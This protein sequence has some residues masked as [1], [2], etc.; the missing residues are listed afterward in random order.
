MQIRYFSSTA[1]QSFL[2]KFHNQLVNST[3]KKHIVQELLKPVGLKQPPT[4]DTKYSAGNSLR[5]MFNDQKTIQRTK[6]LEAE[7][8][9]SGFYDVYTFR[10]TKGKLFL[11]PPSFWKSEKALYFPHLQGRTL[12]SSSLQNTEDVMRGKISI[13]RLFTSNV[14]DDL[15]KSYFTN[16]EVNLLKDESSLTC[17]EDSVPT[18]IVEINLTENFMKSLFVRLAMGKLRK[19]VPQERHSRFFV[20]DRNQMPFSVREELQI[21]NLYTGYVLVVDPNLKIRWMACG[22]ADKKDF[23]LLWKCVRGLKKEFN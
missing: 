13:I 20:C 11:S 17:T 12:S 3:P 9:K 8:S 18:Q 16:D 4:P 14:G 19:T 10:T 23:N 7:F 22:G 15:V 2:K 6:E 5:D 1:T 21:N